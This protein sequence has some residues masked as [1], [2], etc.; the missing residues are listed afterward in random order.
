MS[1]IDEVKA[2][3]ERQERE[4]N[5]ET[6][7]ESSKYDSK[8]TAEEKMPAQRETVAIISRNDEKTTATVQE[9]LQHA[10]EQKVAEGGADIKELARDLTY[11]K[12]ASDLQ[13]DESFKKD[14]Q[15]EL[16]KQMIKDLQDEGKRAAIQQTAKK[17]EEKN[18]RNKAFYE[19]YEPLFKLL[20]IEKAYGL[21]PMIVTVVVV[22]VPF[23]ILS[24][25]RFIFNGTNSLFVAIGKFAKPA[26]LICTTVLIV[27]IAATA[28]VGLMGL[29]DWILGTRILDALRSLK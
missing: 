28:L 1:A 24:F 7:G 25:A 14:Y 27:A 26:F 18:I 2:F 15:E 3:R 11:M 10:M 5:A 8:D 16:A 22:M 19:S 6:A 21:V 9:S 12:G 23:L 4:L 17:L 29:S 13:G 20:S